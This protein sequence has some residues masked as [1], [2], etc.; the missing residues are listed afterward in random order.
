[1]KNFDLSKKEEEA[2]NDWFQE[3]KQECWLYKKG[4][5]RL[6]TFSFTPTGIGCCVE[7]EC[8]CGEKINVTDYESW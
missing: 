4:T 1:M 7:V 5:P 2:Y 8:S 6:N 3:H